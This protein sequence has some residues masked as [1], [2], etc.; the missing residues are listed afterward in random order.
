[1]PVI[2]ADYEKNTNEVFKKSSDLLRQGK[3]IMMFPE[4]TRTDD[5]RVKEFKLG[6]AY[7]AINTGRSIIPVTING[8]YNIWPSSKTFPGLFGKGHASLVIHDK[9][10]PADYK[11]V[12]SLNAKIEEIIISGLDPEINKCLK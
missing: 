12:E 4:G 10:N 5:G 11:T 6:A 1:M 9:I 7:L 3:S 8:A 2:W